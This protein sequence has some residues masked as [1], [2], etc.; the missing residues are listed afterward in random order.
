MEDELIKIWQSSNNQ[1]RIKFNKSKLMIEL[2]SSLERL[3][4]W[5]KYLELVEVI[6]A[7]IIILAFTLITYHSPYTTTKI[8]SVL[9]ILFGINILIKVLGIKKFKPSDLEENYLEYLNKTKEYLEAQKK[10]LD[11]AVYWVVLPIYPILLLF[12]IAFWDIPEQRYL[13]ALIYLAAIGMGIYGYFLNKRRVKNEINPRIA[14]VN[15]LINEL[16]G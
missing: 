11:T 16:N 2:Q 15:Q 1:E 5:W 6:S 12:F 7:I 14:R 13:I 3:H 8:A 9:I 4:R 10:L